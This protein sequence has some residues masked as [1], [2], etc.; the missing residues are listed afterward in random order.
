MGPVIVWSPGDSQQASK[1]SSPL[2][3]LP[4]TAHCLA[5]SLLPK[6]ELASQ[7]RKASGEC[8]LHAVSMTSRGFP[9]TANT[10]SLPHPDAD[11]QSDIIGPS[12]S[13][14]TVWCGRG[15]ADMHVLTRTRLTHQA[16]AIKIVSHG[17]ASLRPKR[18]TSYTSRNGTLPRP[19][20]RELRTVSQ[21]RRRGCEFTASAR[22][23]RS[24]SPDTGRVRTCFNPLKELASLSADLPSPSGISSGAYSAAYVRA[25]PTS[26]N[27]QGGSMPEVLR[28]QLEQNSESQDK[29]RK[30]Q[31]SQLVCLCLSPL[32]VPL[33]CALLVIPERR[34]DT[35]SRLQRTSIRMHPPS[36]PSRSGPRTSVCSV[37]P[38]SLLLK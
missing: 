8:N 16:G 18:R 19:S 2:W 17:R 20:V 14:L 23:S 35:K 27:E 28:S 33:S 12:A 1:R 36:L 15:S 9:D 5:G 13:Q 38:P 21:G 10:C 6:S 25:Q 30:R 37:S 4:T 34:W 26:E 7:D 24:T 32:D 31:T 22:Q 29:R 3:P 11:A